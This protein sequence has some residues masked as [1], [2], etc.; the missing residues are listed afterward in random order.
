MFQ[1][2]L[3]HANFKVAVEKKSIICAINTI[4]ISIIDE[5]PRGDF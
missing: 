2:I 3:L 1:V 5:F 4:V